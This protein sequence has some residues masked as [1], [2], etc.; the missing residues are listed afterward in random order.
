M[1]GIAW[2]HGRRQG[3]GSRD[4]NSA[5][6]APRLFAMAR[7]HDC[8]FGDQITD[9]LKQV[10]GRSEVYRCSGSE[11]EVIL[12]WGTRDRGILA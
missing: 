2:Q 3:L 12:Q 7:S 9:F 6:A 11:L 1:G 4:Q 10:I 8:N 5:A